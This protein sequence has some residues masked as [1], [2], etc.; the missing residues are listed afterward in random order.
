[1]KAEE[2][3]AD[4]IRRCVAANYCWKSVSRGGRVQC[5]YNPEL[6]RE[7]IWGNGTLQRVADPKK[8]LVIGAGPGGL[9]YARIAAA[10]GHEVVVVE[11][12]S[13]VGGHVRL[14]ALLPSRAEYG[15][16][17]TWLA[18]QARK[19]GAEIRTSTPVTPE[20]LDQL[21]ETEEA[22]HVVVA[23]GSSV[24]RD[25]F[26][27]WTAAPIPGHETGNC[28]GWDEVVTGAATV[29]GDVVVLDDLCHVIAPL[30][31]VALKDAGASSVRLVTRWPMIGL[32]TILDVYLDWILP[33]LYETGVEMVVDHFVD[34]I[35]GRTV[36]LVNVHHAEG[37]RET[38]ADALVMVT[39]RRSE[40][41]LYPL[42]RERGVAAELIGDATAPR[43]TYEAV[44]EGHRAARK[45]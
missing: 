27:G 40:N 32:E 31:A 7:E 17:A 5:V 4:D 11:R 19:N 15:L 3:R 39:G 14:E 2:G 12:E 38:E 6:G 18:D 10:R 35:D 20:T 1:V 9:E 41:A 34:S 28:V 37:R 29:S 30:T 36:S 25:G 13:E 44:Y 23:T 33:K 8:V 45:L 21:L 26:Q 43:G 42:L 24:C 22:D 16:I